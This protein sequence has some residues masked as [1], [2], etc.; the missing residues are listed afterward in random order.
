MCE[1]VLS[2]LQTAAD[3]C[4]IHLFKPAQWRNNLT[5]LESEKNNSKNLEILKLIN[6]TVFTQT[7]VLQLYALILQ[8]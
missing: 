1:R 8:E 6:Q 4:P 3:L 2:Q 5:Q 7:G